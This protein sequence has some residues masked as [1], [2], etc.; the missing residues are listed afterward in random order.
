M[1]A[2]SPRPRMRIG[3]VFLGVALIELAL[4]PP[5]NYSVDGASMLATADS[6]LAGQNSHVPCNLGV[7]G[8]GGECFSEWYPLLSLVAIPFLVVGRV[9]GSLSGL[10]TVEVGHVVAMAVPALAVAGAA[11]LTA[12]IAMRVGATARGAV[13]AAVAFAFGTETLTYGRTLYAETLAAFLVALAFWGLIQPGRRR[14]IGLAAIVLAVLAKPQMVVIGPALGLFLAIRESNWRRALG[15]LAATFVGGLLCLAYN[16]F[17][18]NDARDFGRGLNGSYA[19]RQVVEGIGELLISPGRGLLWFSPVMVLGAVALWRYRH[20]A[21]AKVCLA[22]LVALLLVYSA[23]PGSGYEWSTR[24]LVPALPLVAVGVAFVAT[25]R[26]ALVAALILVG[27]VVQLPTT[28]TYYERYFTEQRLQGTTAPEIPWSVAHSPVH[29]TWPTAVRQVSDA[30]E[31]DVQRLVTTSGD[32]SGDDVDSQE[33]FHV[34]ALWWWMLPAAHLPRWLGAVLSLIAIGAGSVIL[35]RAARSRHVRPHL[36]K[37]SSTASAK[38][39][40]EEHSRA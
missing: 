20:H 25:R 39:A 31:A 13:A 18:F 33:R 40:M 22:P 1:E 16:W 35:A 37:A 8:R 6:L 30:Q 32:V 15:P 7:V 17:R 29:G 19:P 14:W 26:A 4:L 27:L 34:V 36:L 11:A 21:L 24:Y 9:L 5:G 38:A 23:A 3:F 12:D 10:P 2:A 28:V